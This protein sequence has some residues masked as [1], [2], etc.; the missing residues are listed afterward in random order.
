MLDFFTHTIN[1]KNTMNKTFVTPPYTKRI[2]DKKI[3][4]NK[5]K[6]MKELMRLF[7]MFQQFKIEIRKEKGWEMDWE[8]IKIV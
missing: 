8:S 6:V 2:L 3:Y 4:K 1:T 5:K 7:P